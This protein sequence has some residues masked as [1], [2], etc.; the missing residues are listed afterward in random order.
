MT[1]MDS[2]E[3]VDA[4]STGP[5]SQRCWSDGTIEFLCI[6]LVAQMEFL[7]PDNSGFVTPI[8]TT[9][10]LS[11]YTL[12]CSKLLRPLSACTPIFALGASVEVHIT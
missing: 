12:Y 8:Y 9:Y 4:H 7:M 2:N 3:E 6:R 5:F 11:F 10:F 1:V